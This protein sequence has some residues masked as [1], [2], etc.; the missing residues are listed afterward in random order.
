MGARTFARAVA[1]RLAAGAALSVAYVPCTSVMVTVT[2]VQGQ[3]DGPSGTKAAPSHSRAQHSRANHLLGDAYERRHVNY[4]VTASSVPPRGQGPRQALG[5]DQVPPHGRVGLRLERHNNNIAIEEGA[6]QLLR[7]ALERPDLCA[8]S[9]PHRDGG[10]A[11]GCTLHHGSVA[12][13]LAIT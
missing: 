3:L 12:A 6:S 8:C 10:D 2:P 4:N 7:H 1:A 9:L 11:K 5:W 13:P